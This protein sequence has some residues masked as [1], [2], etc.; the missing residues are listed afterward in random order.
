MMKNLFLLLSFLSCGL[1]AQAQRPSDYF[2]IPDSKNKITLET[3][4]ELN[5]S[6]NY[7]DSTGAI[8]KADLQK[9]PFEW[10]V[11]GQAI[12]NL[13]AEDGSLTLLEHNKAI[14]TAP[15]LTPAKNPVDI[16]V[17][18]IGLT[19]KTNRTLH[20]KVYI[21]ESVYKITMDAAQTLPAAGQD[22]ELH[23]ECKTILR[24]NPDGT[25]FLEPLDNT[26]NIQI[27]V[28]KGIV[29]DKEG[30]SQ[31]LTAPFSY[32]IPFLFSIDKMNK[33]NP[34]GNGTMFL[35]YTG[36][37]KGQVVW[38]I[39]GDDKVVMKTQDLDKGVIV[40]DP[41]AGPPIPFG[42]SNTSGNADI[43]MGSATEL[44]LISS[45][46][47]MNIG[48]TIDNTRQNIVNSDEMLDFAK[49][50]QA[51]QNDPGYFQ[52]KQGKADMEKLMSLRKQVGE[53][54][55]NTSSQSKEM[56]AGIN[57]RYDNDPNYAG[58]HKMLSDAG[59]V[60]MAGL[61][62]KALFNAPAVA[63]VTPGSALLRIES[64]FNPKAQQAFAKELKGSV[65]AVGQTTVFNIKIIK[66][67]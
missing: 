15:F 11:N 12:N 40:Y 62:D 54:I 44:N 50:I 66:I 1:M 41:S 58:S 35:Y 25:Y 6:L 61:G 46:N 52:T 38:K 47:R 18:L 13:Q 4:G 39:Q 23:G 16:S 5:L 56:N 65:D 33:A 26:R 7:V 30:S 63:Q 53:N 59:K 57:N 20:T 2:L 3:N 34:V 42:I 19:N 37:A 51:H 24:A 9:I 60:Q 31:I 49:R 8:H 36:P 21:K 55:T 22:I 45:I 67:Q 10:K 28:M 48:K 64:K 27:K 43:A 32:T 17:M 14:Y 29:A